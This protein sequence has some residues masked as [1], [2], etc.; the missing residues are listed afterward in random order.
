M[1]KSLREKMEVKVGKMLVWTGEPD[2][3][4]N[5]KL[6]SLPIGE[7]EKIAGN[8]ERFNCKC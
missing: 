3:E 4:M 7:R 5:T 2:K 6:L 8:R 1:V